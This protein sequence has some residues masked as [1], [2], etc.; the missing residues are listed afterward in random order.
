MKN[1]AQHI[2]QKMKNHVIKNQLIEMEIQCFNQIWQ[3]KNFIKN[4]N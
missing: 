2:N 4:R 1:S 3:I